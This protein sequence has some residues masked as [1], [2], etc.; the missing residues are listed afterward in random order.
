VRE[1]GQ[2][3]KVLRVETG[4]SQRELAKLSKV[5]FRQIQRIEKG[6]CDPSLGLADLLFKQFRVELKPLYE[7][8]DWGF[9]SSI[10]WPMIDSYQQK[11][12][13]KRVSWTRVSGEIIYAAKYILRNR[14]EF[15]D[16]RHFDAMKALL[17]AL[18]T[19]YPTKFRELEAILGPKF[20]KPYELAEIRGRDI[21]LRNISLGRL[22][23]YLS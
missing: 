14:N 2:F 12:R 18:K 8:P 20:L 16:D 19:H 6:Q 1:F 15:S 23:K 9:L 4:L 17:F 3:L 10:G 22:Y 13:A 7:E 11:E 21:K 5:S